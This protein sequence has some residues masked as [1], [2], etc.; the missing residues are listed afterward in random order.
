M[1]AAKKKNCR[2]YRLEFKENVPDVT[3]CLTPKQVDKMWKYKG[4]R[5]AFLTSVPTK[6]EEKAAAAK[7]DAEN[8]VWLEKRHRATRRRKQVKGGIGIGAVVL[9]GVGI[10][11]LVRKR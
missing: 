1:K 2:R 4:N 6:A 10:Y 11:F 7:E 9:A 8:R 3:K 5:I